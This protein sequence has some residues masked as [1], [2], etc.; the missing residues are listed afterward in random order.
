MINIV[1]LAMDMNID[2]TI[3]KNQIFTHPTMSEALNDLFNVK[4]IKR[5]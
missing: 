3:L 2:Y 4:Q 5:W 1:K